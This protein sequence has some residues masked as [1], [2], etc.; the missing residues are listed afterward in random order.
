MAKKYKFLIGDWV[1][2]KKFYKVQSNGGERYAYEIGLTKPILGQVCGAVIRHLGKI[3]TNEYDYHNEYAFLVPEKSIILY[4]IKTGMI[5]IAHEVKEEDI[6]HVGF[7]EIDL[8][9]PWK[10]SWATKRD[11]EGMSEATN[12]RL[13]DS[14]GRF[15]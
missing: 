15:L 7:T 9:L 4:Q 14:Q 11:R 1:K 5:N 2:F 8:N 6:T 12:D 10:K 13:R 3:K